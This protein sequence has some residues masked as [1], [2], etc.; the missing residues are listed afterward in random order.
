MEKCYS[1]ETL[2]EDRCARCD[3]WI[4]Q[5]HGYLDDSRDALFCWECSA[6]NGADDS[7]WGDS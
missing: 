3:D 1:C 4:C 6:D 7:D 2:A 5:A